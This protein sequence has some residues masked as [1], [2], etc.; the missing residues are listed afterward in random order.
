MRTLTE[1]R[2]AKRERID[3]MQLLRDL[4][5]YRGLSAQQLRVLY[6]QG[7]EG[8]LYV[9][10]YRLKKKGWVRS[11]PVV[12]HGKKVEVV[13]LVTNE[14]IALLDEQGLIDR[15]RRS[16]HNE[17]DWK[18][19]DD[20]LDQ[21]ELYVQL[22]DLKGV[23]IYDKRTW[24]ERHQVTNTSY[25]CGGIRYLGNEYHVYMLNEN[26]QQRTLERIQREIISEELLNRYI[27]FFKDKVTLDRYNDMIKEEKGKLS[28]QLLSYSYLPLRLGFLISSPYYLPYLLQKRLSE[29]IR[30]LHGEQDTT[31]VF[32]DYEITYQ[33]EPYFVAD[34]LMND[35]II[36]EQVKGYQGSGFKRHGKKVFIVCWKEKMADYQSMVDPRKT[37]FFG[38][39]EKDFSFHPFYETYQK[40]IETLDYRDPFRRKREKEKIRTNMRKS[41]KR[42]KV[43][44]R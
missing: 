3:D 30:S 43:T 10:M 29:P 33:G 1:E 8:Y 18:R 31:N 7:S 21:N 34:M 27:F 41:R 39:T 23:E 15:V 9:K 22:R 24:K 13:Y 4:Y 11:K 14:G 28:L 16:D 12:W 37:A 36:L 32:A 44:A 25:V 35:H 20:V 40:R 26:T 5:M 19:I 6:F 42:N 17:P 38:V 2:N